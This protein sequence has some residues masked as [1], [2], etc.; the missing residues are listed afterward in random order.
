MDVEDEEMSAKNINMGARYT[1]FLKQRKNSARLLMIRS[2]PTQKKKK[3]Y[4]ANK[5]CLQCIC[6]FLL[7][8]L[9][10]GEPE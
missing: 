7:L 3:T 9:S 8:Y 6:I 2:L 5:E 10:S 4:M 1:Q